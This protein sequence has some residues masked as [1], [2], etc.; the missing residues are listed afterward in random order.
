MSAAEVVEDLCADIDGSQKFDP[1]VELLDKLEKL[2]IRRPDLVTTFGGSLF[3][4]YFS[5]M[6]EQKAWR[7]CERI[8]LSTMD[9]EDKVQAKKLEVKLA[10][11]FPNSKRLWLLGG[12][13]KESEGAFSDAKTMYKDVLKEDPNNINAKK[14]LIALS[15]SES[16]DVVQK[17]KDYLSVYCNDPEAWKM[18]KNVYLRR[19]N[20]RQ[21]AYC[22]EEII[23]LG[24]NDYLLYLQL[25][26]LLFATGNQDDCKM[27]LKYYQMSMFL[28]SGKNN[29]RAYLGF[30]NCATKGCTSEILSK[31]DEAV[32][33]RVKRRISQFYRESNPKY[34]KLFSKIN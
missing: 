30:M 9:T 16:D 33:A 12:V 11:R 34:A 8:Y 31:A 28:N 15:G 29:L 13:R 22:V 5:K 10:K 19:G 3:E 7:L 23:L 24:P 1:L 18:L 17:L 25:A 26:E 6:T 20:Y 2:K 21:A 27:A 14:R 32:L 4:K